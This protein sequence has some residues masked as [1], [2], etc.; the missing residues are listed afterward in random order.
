MLLAG[1]RTGAAQHAHATTADFRS[2][3]SKNSRIKK[4]AAGCGGEPRLKQL[5]GLA[6]IQGTVA[7]LATCYIS[8][9]AMPGQA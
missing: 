2:H 9:V 8:L 5:Q 3:W 1:V 4:P 6:I 7:H